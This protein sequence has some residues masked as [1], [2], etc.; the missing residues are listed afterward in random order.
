MGCMFCGAGT[1][2]M[3]CDCCTKKVERF[4]A[5]LQAMEALAL[6]PY[7]DSNLESFVAMQIAVA[8]KAVQDAKAP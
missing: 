4:D 3:V 1:Y 5:L 7:S 6:P 8:T 2:H